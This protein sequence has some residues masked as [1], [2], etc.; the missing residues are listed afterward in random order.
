MF[1]FKSIW[2]AHENVTHLI[3]K[4][5][6]SSPWRTQVDSL[7]KANNIHWFNILAQKVHSSN[8]ASRLFVCIVLMQ[9]ETVIWVL[10][11]A[12]LSSAFILNNRSFSWWCHQMETFSALLA[13][14]AG[15]SPV[16]GKF[17]TQ[18]PVTRSFDVFFELRL[19]IQLNK[20]WWGWWFETLS[21]SSW[22]HCNVGLHT[23]YVKQR[24][25]IFWKEKIVENLWLSIQVQRNC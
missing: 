24:Q 10:P 13:L 21:R 3:P 2:N 9:Q 17:P 8:T 12:F 15:N 23:G 20:R 25:T 22:R 14:C 11:V 5:V 1:F 7:Q 18:R 6:T 16:T 4:L 19:N